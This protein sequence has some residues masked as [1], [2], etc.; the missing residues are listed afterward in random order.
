MKKVTISSNATVELLYQSAKNKKTLV[1]I[2][3]Q[4]YADHR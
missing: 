2:Q 3:P 1:I 4:I